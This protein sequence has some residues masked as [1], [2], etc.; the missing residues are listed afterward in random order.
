M[1]QHNDPKPA[2]PGGKA[3]SDTVGG[4]SSGTGAGE[5][6]AVADVGAPYGTRSRNRNGNSRPNYAEDKDIDMDMY[7]FY[8]PEK[9]DKDGDGGKKSSSRQAHAASN[10]ETGR[11]N[12]GSRKAAADDHK[13]GASQNGHRDSSSGSGSAASQAAQGQGQAQAQSQASGATQSSSRKRKTAGGQNG[14]T[15]AA[16]SKK[17][18]NGTVAQASPGVNWP[19][20]NMLTFENCHGRP[21][22]GRMVA[23][24]GTALAANDHVYLV[25]EPPGEPYYL[26]RIMEFLH[27]KNDSSKPVDAIRVNWYYRPKDIGRKVQDTRLVFATMH[28]DITPLTALR[29]KCQIRHRCEIDIMDEYRKTPDSFWFE[30][31]YDRYIQK[32]YDL[33]PTRLIV[34]VPEKVKKVLDE[35]WKYV[36]VEQGRGKEL[37]SAVKSCKRCSGY[38]ARREF[39]IRAESAQEVLR[40]PLKPTPPS[41]TLRR[42]LTPGLLLFLQSGAPS[43]FLT[44]AM[45]PARCNFSRFARDK[46]PNRSH[47]CESLERK[48]EARHTPHT[49]H[50]GD[51][52]DDECMDD[53]DDD[54][55]GVQTNR[56]TPA[57]DDVPH[58]G[59]AEQIYQASLWPYRYL[60]MHCRPEDALDYD[61]R[62]YPRASTRVGPRNQANVLPWPGRPVEYVKPLEVKKPG[63]KEP[64]LSKEALAAQEAEKARRGNRPKWIQDE[65]SGYVARG[66]DYPEDDPRCTAT[67]LWIPPPPS[68]ISNERIYS[69]VDKAMGL[70]KKLD[71]PERSTN[72]RDAAVQTLFRE[73]FNEDKALKSIPEIP[74]SDF[75]EPSLTPAEQKKFED[76]VS[77]YGSE[78]HLV[79]KYVKT[80]TPGETVRYY[81]KWKKTERGQ[82]V[83]GNYPG[84]KGK[85]QARQAEAA[86]SKFADDVADADDDSAFDAEKAV[87]KKR[88]F[89]CQFC[90]TTRSRQWRRAPSTIAGLVPSENGSKANGK[91]K[92]SQS[93]VALCRRCAELWRRY[94]IQW[95]DID[96]VARKVAQAG[97]RAWKR[98]QDEELLKELQ[99]AQEFGFLTPERAS[100]PTS[101]SQPTNGQEPPR[102]KLKSA[103]E[104]DVDVAHYKCVLCPVE[105]TEHDLVDQMK[106][107]HHKKKMT[108]KERERE[109]LEVQQARKAVEFYRKKQEELNRPINPREPLKRTAD[110][111][112][113]HVTCAVWTA[114]VRFGNAKAMGPSEGIPSIPRSKYDEITLNALDSMKGQSTH[115]GGQD[116]GSASSDWKSPGLDDG[117][118]DGDDDSS[119]NGCGSNGNIDDDDDDDTDTDSHAIGSS[120]NQWLVAADEAAKP[121]VN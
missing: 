75:K 80:M 15:A 18:A 8:S 26:G 63:R 11:A 98:K 1:A 59:T 42:L 6:D 36:L 77:K 52:E 64:R 109:R 58:L 112:W 65:P 118:D 28:S 119:G 2:S 38:C 106:L 67:P 108:E 120:S 45:I 101:S 78:L 121:I 44:V 25:C 40:P 100:T 85:K 87:E 68:V 91:E 73:K 53:D 74:R 56:T 71:L 54:A 23:D 70:A 24:N 35:R 76:G 89:V 51:I 21:E 81:Y 92:S 55:H 110:N 93:V 4:G 34:N 7:E 96:E 10:G 72:L 66:E 60:G 88:G 114:E 14:G 43:L 57:D 90:N 102:K 97:G 83:W 62:I 117:D 84:R 5:K 3:A 37:T 27:Q 86:A 116:V 113:V 61:D 115:D 29:G 32:N 103:P 107:T 39:C 33:I 19:D 47:A 105:H 17:S 50:H 95:E 48:I 13:S 111:N 31:L 20:T 16:T 9:K 41:L 30:K 79:M 82:Q 22:N 69:Y 12:G 104:K 49:I 94:A 99:A 46:R